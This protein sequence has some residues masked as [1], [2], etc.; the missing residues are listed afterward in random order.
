A[1]PIRR[2][3]VIT[4]VERRRDWTNE[5]K[6][7]IIAESCQDGAVISDVARRHGLRPQQLF[8]WRNEFRKRKTGL[9]C[10]GT[11]AFAPVMIADDRTSAA[12]TETA[13]PVSDAPLIEIVLGGVMVR[14]RGSVDAKALAAVLR[15]V[16]AVA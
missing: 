6:L 13:V 3:E 5:Q 15:A 10:G 14:T 11:P 9:V 8:N 1:T 16:K 12:R 2:V 4:G 7:S